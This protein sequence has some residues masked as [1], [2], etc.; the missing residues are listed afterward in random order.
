[1]SSMSTYFR[2]KVLTDNLV[3][4]QCYVGLFNDGVEVAQS[5][6]LRQPVVFDGAIDG[7][8]MNNKDILFP[9]ALSDWGEVNQIGI[10]DAA[11]GGN[12]LFLTNA[13]FVKDI[14]VSSQ[15]KIPQ[16]YLIARVM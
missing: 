7:Q 16:N 1:M 9:I 8:L 6:Y 15:Y 5:D 14:D 2:N 3:N 12:Q 11:I 13:E 4:Q 10:V